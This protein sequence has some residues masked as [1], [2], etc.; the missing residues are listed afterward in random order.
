MSPIRECHG[1]ACLSGS[2]HASGLNLSAAMCRP[3]LTTQHGGRAFTRRDDSRNI[4][5]ALEPLRN[6]ARAICCPSTRR[7]PNEPIKR[8]EP[9]K[10]ESRFEDQIQEHEWRNGRRTGFRFRRRKA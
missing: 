3:A 7:P 4:R 9:G 10:K 2:L 1:A 5:G 6:G 8:N